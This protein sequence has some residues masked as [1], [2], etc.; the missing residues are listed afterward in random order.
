[1]STSRLAFLISVAAIGCGGVDV[2]DIRQHQQ[3]WREADIQ[4]YAFVT[5]VGCF[6]DLTDFDGIRHEVRNGHV[7]S[8]VGVATGLPFS[9]EARTIDDIFEE[10]ISSA[11]EDP[12]V[13]RI[14][15]DETHDFIRALEVDSDSDAEDDGFTIEV[16]CFSTDVDNGCPVTTLSE[17]ECA[18]ADGT[19]REVAEPDP[20]LTCEPAYPGPIGRISSSDRVCCTEER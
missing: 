9:E 14:R 1:M 15:Y 10:A 8:A 4:D 2:D 18:E 6:C 11:R 17:A 20:W 3:S 13:F 12:D 19:P 16:R 7:V 5:H